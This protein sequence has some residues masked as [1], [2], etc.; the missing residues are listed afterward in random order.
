MRKTLEN[1]MTSVSVQTSGPTGFAS[2]W[3][4]EPMTLEDAHGKLLPL[5]LELVFSWEAK[6]PSEQSCPV[7]DIPQM[8][9]SVLLSHFRA[10]AGKKKVQKREFEIE[11]SM[12]RGTMPRT[13]SWSQFSE[14]GRKFEMSTIFK[15]A[16]RNSVV[17]P[18][19]DT[20][21][22]EKKGVQVE[23]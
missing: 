16:G 3:K 4:Q 2:F 10:R 1:V 13:K 7:V 5:P 22:Q 17:C 14:P 18:K 19:C 11:D 8:F 15:D 6:Y 23:W 9:D 12:S 21:S 20:I